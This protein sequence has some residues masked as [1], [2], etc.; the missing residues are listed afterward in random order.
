[1]ARAI[2]ITDTATQKFAEE[3]VLQMEKV[4]EDLEKDIRIITEDAINKKM[5]VATK[6]AAM[7]LIVKRL[8]EAQET[9]D[10][11]LLTIMPESYRHGVQ[12]AMKT[13]KKF[14]FKDEPLGAIH[15]AQINALVSD[16]SLDFGTGLMG[17]RKSSNGIMSRVLQE[18]LRDRITE[19][20][21]AGK[22]IP[23]IAAKIVDDFKDVGFS[24]FVDRGGK[25]WS[26]K[27]Y[28][29][30]LTR[31]HII[32]AANEASLKRAGELG[33][34]IF[35]MSTHAGT[36]DE[37]CLIVE[38]KFYDTTGK[39]YPHPPSMPIHPNCRHLLL[40]RPDL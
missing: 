20:V 30:M 17:V 12:E 40:P 14:G 18:Q 22:G 33:V 39:R 13:L 35:Q 9:T 24:V 26:L 1:M 37:A 32:R 11:L 28:A 6:T 8:T 27:R 23:V 4:F 2:K 16:A 19:G 31:T 15:A 38:G 36:P 21:A 10:I 34:T 29:E 5:T 7:A 25:K 3:K